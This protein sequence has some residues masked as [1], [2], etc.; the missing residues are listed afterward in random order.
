MK[1]RPNLVLREPVKLYE[2]KREVIVNEVNLREDNEIQF[3]PIEE[4]SIKIA[5]NKE[6]EEPKNQLKESVKDKMPPRIG[7]IWDY[8]CRK[9][10][11]DGEI[12]R[13]FSLT[14]SEVMKEAGIGSTNTYRDALKRFQDMGLLEIELRPGVGSGSVF[15]LTEK[16]IEQID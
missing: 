16:G 1:K 3:P 11:S 12:N 9:A 8:F 10:K 2:T 7:Q 13:S 14:R 5:Q 4:K 6:V 15:T